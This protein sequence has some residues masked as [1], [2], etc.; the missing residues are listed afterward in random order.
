MERRKVR[1]WLRGA[2]TGAASEKARAM[3]P[4]AEAASRRRRLGGE[5]TW[6]RMSRAQQRSVAVVEQDSSSSSS[7]SSSSGARAEQSRERAERV[8]HRTGPYR[9]LGVT[10]RTD[11]SS[12]I[13]LIG[14]LNDRLHTPSLPSLCPSRSQPSSSIAS[15]CA[16]RALLQVP[17]H[18]VCRLAPPAVDTHCDHLPWPA[19]RVRLRL[20]LWRLHRRA[21]P[22]RT[23][24]SLPP[25]TSRR[26]ACCRCAA[27]RSTR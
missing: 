15:F 10:D 2:L 26:A 23:C 3:H 18:T 25:P 22:G 9:K 7:S 14:R 12:P 6:P 1:C 27:S 4:Q 8:A 5:R 19:R 20:R 11:L 16:S 13:A 21:P 17:L 24:S